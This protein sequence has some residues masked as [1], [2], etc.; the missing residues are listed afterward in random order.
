MDKKYLTPDFDVTSYEVKDV[1]T[2]EPTDGDPD[3]LG[4][5]VFG[6]YED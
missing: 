3:N 6:G 5:N 4:S 2:A 1:I